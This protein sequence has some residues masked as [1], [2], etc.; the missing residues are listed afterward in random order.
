ML[1][2]RGLRGSARC[3][4]SLIDKTAGASLDSIL[5]IDKTASKGSSR[6]RAGVS[7]SRDGESRQPKHLELAPELPGRTKVG[8][9]GSARYSVRVFSFCGRRELGWYRPVPRDPWRNGIFVC[10]RERQTKIGRNPDRLD[11]TMKIR[12]QAAEA[13]MVSDSA[14]QAT[15][16]VRDRAVVGAGWEPVAVALR[17]NQAGTRSG[18]LA[19]L[20]S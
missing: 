11:E 9:G 10:R 8:P 5:Q 19:L 14:R 20:L 16:A 2:C 15:P 7:A 6:G 4:S 17:L 12:S 1:T 18:L 13:P 3:E